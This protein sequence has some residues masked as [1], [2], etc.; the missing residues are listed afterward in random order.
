M[1]NEYKNI[2]Y[3][4]DYYNNVEKNEY[5][6]I[7]KP[8]FSSKNILIMEYVDGILLDEISVSE[9]EKKKICALFSLFVKNNYF[10]MDY[11]HNDIHNANW[12]II[13]YGGF[14]KLVIYDFG[15]IIKN[16]FK[17]TLKTMIF[18]FDT[19]N[20]SGCAKIIYKYVENKYISEDD[21]IILFL[22]YVDKTL[23]Y[24][25]NFLIKL[26]NFL[27]INN[28]KIIDNLLEF[29]ILMI[30]IRKNLKKY[31]L[32][33]HDNN[34]YEINYHIECYLFFNSIIKQYNIFKNIGDYFYEYYFNNPDYL[35]LLKYKDEY[36]ENLNPDNRYETIDI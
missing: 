27:F 32:Q 2:T 20:R 18:C 3:F 22:K 30:L 9:N 28:F 29:F 13:Q 7:P 14:Y 4:Y 17:N 23:P 24:N 6:I 35:K 36:L 5:I 21:F 10:F 12:K 15:Y 33:L 8:I 19:N 25:D 1:N 31:F 26:Y 16:S 11:F 34:K